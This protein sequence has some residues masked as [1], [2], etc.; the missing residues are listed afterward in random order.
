VRIVGVQAERAPS[1]KLSWQK[2][3]PVPTDTCDTI[4]DGLATRTPDP[5]NV[6]DICELV[7]EVRLVSERQMLEAIRHLIMEEHIVAEPAG[8]AATAALLA[9]PPT[10]TGA[11]VALVSG[12][13]IAPAV[14]RA[15]LCGLPD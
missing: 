3:T 14:L 2:K 6:H 7:D 5:D 4:A 9:D 11:I 10:S 13:N 15:A 12:A 8:A 1:Y